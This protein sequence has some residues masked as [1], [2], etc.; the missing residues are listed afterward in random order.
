[1][2]IAT[3]WEALANTNVLVF[4]AVYFG[5]VFTKKQVSKLMK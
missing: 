4:V 1:M 3:I 5:V 2:S